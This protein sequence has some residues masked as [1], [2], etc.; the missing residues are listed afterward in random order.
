MNRAQENTARRG[1]RRAEEMDEDDDV[2]ML[3]EPRETRSTHNNKRRKFYSNV[4][5][6]IFLASTEVNDPPEPFLLSHGSL[7]NARDVE[8]RAKG[9]QREHLMETE[10]ET[11]PLGGVSRRKKKKRV[12]VAPIRR[13]YERKIEEL[14]NQAKN[15][16]LLV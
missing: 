4:V 16:S 6:L 8:P 14:K 10:Q 5:K 11:N 15:H 9:A 1:R 3:A 7:R 13:D 12:Y 2:I